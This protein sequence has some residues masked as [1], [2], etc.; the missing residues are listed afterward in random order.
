MFLIINNNTKFI[1]KLT[2]PPIF[3]ATAIIF[4]I[5]NL[6]PDA[7]GKKAANAKVN[8]DD[9]ELSR[10]TTAVSVISNET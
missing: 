6:S 2:T 10:V 4:V 3:I 8:N 5:L 9:E 7:E 1:L